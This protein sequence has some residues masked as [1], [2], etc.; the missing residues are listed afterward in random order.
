MIPEPGRRFGPYEIQA[1]LGSG[2]MGHVFR[3]WD[4]RLRREVAIKFLHDEFTVPGMRERF[5]REAQAA[6]ALT[7][8]N[9]CTIF[10]IGEQDGEPYLVM[11]LLQGETLK[12]RISRSGIPAEELITIA[13][14]VAEGLG[15]AHAKGIVHRDVKPAN[16]FLVD[17]PNG[18]VQA[19]VLD[20]GLAKVDGGSV[21]LRGRRV[22]LTTAGSAV[23]T[24]AYM[25]PEQARGEVLDLRSDLFSLGVVL[26]EMA[27]GQIPFQGTT[28]A[29]V[30]VK[31]LNHSPDPV[32]EWNQQIPRDLERIILKLMEKER[33]ARYQTA[34]ELE[35]ALLHLSGR[36]SG[37]RWLRKAKSSIPL[38]KP[39]ETVARERRIQTGSDADLLAFENGS[40]TADQPGSSFPSS[41]SH[42]LRPI[43]RIPLEQQAAPSLSGTDGAPTPGSGSGPVPVSPRHTPRERYHPDPDQL[44]ASPG[45]RAET[46]SPVQTPADSAGPS[47]SSVVLPY[48]EHAPPVSG[49]DETSGEELG[50]MPIHASKERSPVEGAKELSQQGYDERLEDVFAPL[51]PLNPPFRGHL[52]RRARLWFVAGAMVLSLAVL[53]LFALNR[54]HLGPTYLNRRDLLVMTAIENHTGNKIFDGSLAEGLRLDLEQSPYLRNATSFAYFTAFYQGANNTEQSAVRARAAA[55]RLG[56]K[57]Y[58]YGRITNTEVTE[59]RL[60]GTSP[61]YALHIDLLRVSNNEILASLD[62]NATS[63]QQIPSAID[64][65][66]AEIRSLAG[67]DSRAIDQT[68]NSLALEAT[69]DLDAL[70]TFE[71]AETDLAGGRTI[72]ALVLYQKALALDPHFVQANLRLAVLYRKQRAEVAASDAA[73]AALTSSEKCSERVRTLAQYEFEMNTSGDFDRATEIIHG[74][75][76]QRPH[77]SEAL[78]D[79][80]RVERLEGKLTDALQHAQNAIAEDPLNLDAYIQASNALI[81]LDRYDAA[82]QV[83]QAA[84]RQG[85]V[86][87]G[88]SLIGGYLSGREDLLSRAIQEYT[89]NRP[90]YRSDWAYGLYLDN[91]GRLSEG[92]TLWRANAAA[93]DKIDNLASASAYLLA[94]A[95]LDRALVGDCRNALP[96]AEDSDLKPQ[97]MVTSFNSGMAQ[98]LCGSS[99]HAQ[100]HID[101]L[102]QTLPKSTDVREYLVPDI[103]AAIALHANDPAT[104]LE[105]L[106]PVRRYDLISLTPYLR[107]RAHV[108]LGQ[109]QIGIVD[110]QTVLSH[111]GITFT[112]GTDVY[113]VAEIG[114]ARAFAAT[115]DLGNSAAAYRQFLQLWKTL[116]PKNRFCW[117]R[118]RRASDRKQ[119][120]LAANLSESFQ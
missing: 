61:A 73:R 70:K 51:E 56:A 107:G 5:L 44:F 46:P 68:H 12:S 105:E 84:Q 26:Y 16:I 8:P 72:N 52:K 74:W 58:L 108:A 36:P 42:L 37:A 53:V 82:L 86:R 6:S 48:G 60:R 45:L 98:A 90:A 81:G 110:F 69:G 32:R 101:T 2:G 54:N 14:D 113:P 18:K 92:S 22:D 31:L 3:A 65:L 79:L 35:Q 85:L 103:K 41:D 50:V 4:G 28:S 62:D 9:I 83:E 19:K 10:D 94:Q 120:P 55:Q 80:A 100:K 24:L 78:S 104:A 91:T 43:S 17:K 47:A 67:E 27:T 40:R 118:D 39:I 13:K 21:A 109:M 95:A 88:G 112:V 102:R 20:F 106:R 38:P 111:R 75:L 97:G 11:E 57:A 99:D 76:N 59:E 115:G 119:P 1:R 63:L 77:D 25:S 66:A 114:V 89:S 30:F 7:H 33:T 87:V 71:Q 23:G 116:T 29:F 93:A 96:L 34:G 15:A 49:K 64:R 117:K